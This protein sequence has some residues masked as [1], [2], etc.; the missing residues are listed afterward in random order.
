MACT[1]TYPQTYTDCVHTCISACTYTCVSTHR[2]KHASTCALPCAPCVHVCACTSVNLYTHVHAHRHVPTNTHT[3][4]HRLAHLHSLG[5]ITMT[6]LRA[7]SFELELGKATAPRRPQEPLFSVPDTS[8]QKPN[9]TYSLEW[10]PSFPTTPLGDI[11]SSAPH[12]LFSS[13]GLILPKSLIIA[14]PSPGA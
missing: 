1:S 14:H 11:C 8:Q 13:P 2:Y 12:F 7:L 4:T 5:H 10:E 9:L 3:E 6:D